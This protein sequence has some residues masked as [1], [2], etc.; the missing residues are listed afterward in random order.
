M[1]NADTQ[2]LLQQTQDLRHRVGDLQ[3]RIRRRSGSGLP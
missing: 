1:N 2:Y 3:K